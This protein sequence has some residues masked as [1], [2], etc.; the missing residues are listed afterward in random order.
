MDSIS[1]FAMYN[2]LND[3]AMLDL[4]SN[5]TLRRPDCDFGLSS[6]MPIPEER[7]SADGA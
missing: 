5:M 7:V 6:V 2:V 1:R 4:M 3:G